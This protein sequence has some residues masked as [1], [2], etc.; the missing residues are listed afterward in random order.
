MSNKKEIIRDQ[1]FKIRMSKE[2][3]ELWTVFSKKMGLMP[4]KSARN[5]L[6]KKAEEK[7]KHRL[8]FRSIIQA[9]KRYLEITNQKQTATSK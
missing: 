7:L 5:L 6:M 2:E 8:K 4:S 1:Y 9:Y 3:K